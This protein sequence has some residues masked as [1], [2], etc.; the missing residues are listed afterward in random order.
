MLAIPVILGLHHPPVVLVIIRGSMRGWDSASA[1]SQPQ[2]LYVCN[3]E[4]HHQSKMGAIPS[5][6][7]DSPT[8]SKGLRERRN[9]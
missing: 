5:Y 8:L 3:P 6:F 7:A 9:L 4:I 2:R 1:C